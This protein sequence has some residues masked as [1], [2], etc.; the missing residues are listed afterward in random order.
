M[1][2]VFQRTDST[3]ALWP[4]AV[5]ALALGLLAASSAS[6]QPVPF[7][8]RGFRGTRPPR[9]TVQPGEAARVEEEIDGA[10]RVAILNVDRSTLGALVEVRLRDKKMVNWWP[11]PATSK[12]LSEAEL[13]PA[14]DLPAAAD[15][16]QGDKPPL[17]DALILVRTRANADGKQAEVVVCE[18]GL[19]LRLGVKRVPLTGEPARDVEAL[20]DAATT[21]LKK[22][23]EKLRQL[24]AVPPFRSSDLVTTNTDLRSSFAREA[25]QAL[26][27]QKGTFAVELEYAHVIAAARAIAGIDEGIRRPVPRFVLGEYRHEKESSSLAIRLTIQESEMP[28]EPRQLPAAA[29]EAAV[30]SLQAALAEIGKSTGDVQSG[31]GGSAEKNLIAAASR[32]YQKEGNWQAALALAESRLLLDPADRQWRSHAIGHAVKLVREQVEGLRRREAPAGLTDLPPTP[33][34][35]GLHLRP[36]SPEYVKPVTEALNT[37]RRAMHH[38]QK[39]LSTV[40]PAE[41][42][43]THAWIP[44]PGHDFVYC[45]LAF[46]PAVSHSADLVAIVSEL[47]RQRQALILRYNEIAAANGEAGDMIVFS[48]LMPEERRAL[49]VRMI[50]DFRNYPRAEIRNQAYVRAALSYQGGKENVEPFLAQLATIPDPT[51]QKVVEQQ[52][53]QLTR[54]ATSPQPTPMPSRTPAPAVTPDPNAQIAFTPLALPWKTLLDGPDSRSTCELVVPLGKMGDLFCYRGQILLAKKKG[55]YKLIWE[56]SSNLM[57]RHMTSAGYGPSLACYDGK[58][59]WVPLVDP[60]TPARLLVIDPAT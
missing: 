23:G 55:E 3:G 20:A 11:R 46:P 1:S 45:Q 44:A 57:F 40:P 22:L 9:P 34:V 35:G 38:F 43:G 53:Q 14:I 19:G 6:A 17:P 42:R 15:D 47:R 39:Q 52:R 10:V 18:P 50:V 32:A 27:S 8:A 41:G 48:E 33:A 59:A 36:L 7:P 12:L 26:L 60:G 29:A 37:Y 54:T 13:H 5:I 24:W 56:G 2:R 51:V 25:E 28:G 21:G 16:G 49:V 58:Y 4:A 31:D 30:H